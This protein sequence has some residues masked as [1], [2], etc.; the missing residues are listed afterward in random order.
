MVV[1]TRLV[2]VELV[3]QYMPAGSIW[4]LLL[5]PFQVQDLVPEV[6]GPL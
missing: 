3:I 2:P 6:R 1:V 5:R 4:P